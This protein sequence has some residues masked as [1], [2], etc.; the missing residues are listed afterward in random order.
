MNVRRVTFMRTKNH[1][2][3]YFVKWQA[4]V[5][6]LPILVQDMSLLNNILTSSNVKIIV[7]PFITSCSIIW[8]N[9]NTII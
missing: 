9:K 8:V 7:D 5:A 2:S 1:V 4:A 3:V 6:V